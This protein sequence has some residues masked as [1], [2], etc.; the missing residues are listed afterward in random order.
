MLSIAHCL[1]YIYIDPEDVSEVGSPPIY[2]RLVLIILT[3]F[4]Q[5]SIAKTEFLH[6]LSIE[7]L[8]MI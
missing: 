5:N 8:G 2:T 1:R 4:Y 7:F 6:I 3:A